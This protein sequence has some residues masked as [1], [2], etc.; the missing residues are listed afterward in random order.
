MRVTTLACLLRRGWP[1]NETDN[2]GLEI[3]DGLRA[4]ISGQGYRFIH[5]GLDEGSYERRMAELIQKE[6]VSGVIL[7]HFTPEETIRR[8]AG[9][10]VPAVLFNRLMNV[11]N[12]SA[13]SP[14][15]HAAGRETF[16]WF[17]ARGY[18][19]I[20]FYPYSTAEE[21]AGLNAYS[22]EAMYEGL[23]EEVRAAGF[24]FENLSA[25]EVPFN[26]PPEAVLD[27]LQIP[28]KKGRDWERLGILCYIDTRANQVIDA[29]GCTDL[30]LGRDIGVIGFL[31]L[32]SGRQHRIPPTTWRVDANA[33]GRETVRELLARIGDPSLPRSTV[34]LPVEFVDRGTA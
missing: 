18:R 17:M 22:M 24:P 14:D 7:D 12:L 25:R 6:W 34:K 28:R 3:V 20:V 8:L 21:L 29:V 32:I 16:K 30:E 26:A 11:P 5:H 19:R 9:M 4:E 10:G 23:R 33:L 2:F 13:V 15:Y 1:R 31:D 27:R